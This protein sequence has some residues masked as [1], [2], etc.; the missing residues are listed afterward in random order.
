MDPL[1]SRRHRRHPELPNLDDLCSHQDP[2]RISSVSV[3]DLLKRIATERQNDKLQPFY[4]IRTVANYFHIPP[5]KVSRIYQ[6]LSSERLLRMVWGS[7]TLL[8]PHKSSRNSKSMSVGVAVN[9][10]RFVESSD[11]RVSILLLQL[12]M[13][14]HEVDDHLLFFKE[15]S[16]EI[17]RL[18]TRNHHPRINT[19]VW[20]LPEASHN[21]TLLR[22]RDLG[23]RVI[24]VS[25]HVIR[26]IPDCYIISPRYTIRAIVRKRI[27]N[28]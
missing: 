25:D 26:G 27:L 17:A 18:C 22:L 1:Q 6:R 24:C 2:S 15:D 3:Q 4:S 14:N 19:I 20:L 13:W 7:R 28:I 10:D 21:Q 11:Y 5:A 8:E 16:S 9:L 23:L 12:E